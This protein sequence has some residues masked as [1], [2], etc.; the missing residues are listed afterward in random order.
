MKALRNSSSGK[1]KAYFM[2]L[3]EREGHPWILKHA[4]W[5]TQFNT[6]SNAARRN[7]LQQVESLLITAASKHKKRTKRPQTA[8]SFRSLFAGATKPIY[9]VS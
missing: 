9:K 1:S 7:M 3:L 5:H 8:F 6:L 4:Y 2:R